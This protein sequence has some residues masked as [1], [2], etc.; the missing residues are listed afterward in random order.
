MVLPAPEDGPRAPDASGSASDREMKSRSRVTGTL[1][2]ADPGLPIVEAR[3]RSTVTRFFS[4]SNGTDPTV[5][6]DFLS[7]FDGTLRGVAFY[8]LLRNASAS[9]SFGLEVLDP[10]AGTATPVFTTSARLDLLPGS[11]EWRLST[12]ASGA[13]DPANLGSAFAPRAGGVREVIFDA[14]FAEVLTDAI[15]VP[16]G[17]V[18]GLSWFLETAAVMQGEAVFSSFIEADFGNTASFDFR[19]AAA[20]AATASFEE[21]L[22][23]PAATLSAPGTTALCLLALLPAALSRMR[24]PRGLRA[25]HGR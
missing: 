14:I 8:E 25:V 5:D 13:A 7:F 22:S 11:N 4:F 24:R 21:V 17:T 10:A 3:N 12:R 23:V 1:G 2:A 16:V 9:M 19:I 18:I 15:T 6:L 20:D